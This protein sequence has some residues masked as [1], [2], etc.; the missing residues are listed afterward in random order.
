MKHG[1]R[2]YALFEAMLDFRVWIE[3][4]PVPSM[5]ELLAYSGYAQTNGGKFVVAGGIRTSYKNGPGPTNWVESDRIYS[6]DLHNYTVSYT[7]L[8]ILH[9]ATDFVK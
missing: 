5:P 1:F 3:P 4:S 8:N 6:L 2:H 7:L 9:Q